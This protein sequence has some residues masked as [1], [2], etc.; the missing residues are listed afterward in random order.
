MSRLLNCLNHIN[1]DFA[2]TPD[3]CVNG[4]TQYGFADGR[5]TRLFV[6]NDEDT[7]SVNSFDPQARSFRT[8]RFPLSQSAM[9]KARAARAAY[10]APRCGADGAASALGEMQSGVTALL[11]AQPTE[12]LVYTCSAKSGS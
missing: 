2:W 1:M 12:R 4:R 11:P 5:W 6:P 10:Q 9:A 3:G 7:I 8:D